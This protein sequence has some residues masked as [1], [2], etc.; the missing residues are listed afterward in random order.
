M[1]VGVNAEVGNVG[2][3][4]KLISRLDIKLLLISTISHFK[5]KHSAKVDDLLVDGHLLENS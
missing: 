5:S 1:W 4:Y 3:N 2:L